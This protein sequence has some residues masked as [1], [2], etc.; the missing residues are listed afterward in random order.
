MR[1][2]NTAGLKISIT[3]MINKSSVNFAHYIT[4]RYSSKKSLKI[5]YVI[6]KAIYNSA[7]RIGCEEC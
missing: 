7:Q 5:T 4:K 6:R 2:N 1:K 3:F